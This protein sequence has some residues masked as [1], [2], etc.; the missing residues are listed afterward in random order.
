MDLVNPPG[1]ASVD[2][3]LYVGAAVIASAIIT[4]KQLNIP[5]IETKSSLTGST[6]GQYGEHMKPRLMPT[7]MVAKI[8]ATRH[9]ACQQGQQG[10]S[11]CLSLCLSFSLSSS[12]CVETI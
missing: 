5:H 11:S 10:P 12:A 8:R 4:A 2:D 7:F 6:R 3:D 9:E 1:E